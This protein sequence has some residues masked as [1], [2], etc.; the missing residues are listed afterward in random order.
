M[1]TK[2]S[3]I[4]CRPWKASA[5]GSLAQPD[6]RSQVGERRDVAQAAAERR[7]QHDADVVAPGLAELAVDAQRVVGTA[8]VLHVDPHEDPAR[9]RVGHDRRDERAAQVEI[10]L[11]PERGQLHGHVRVQVVACDGVQDR[12]VGIRHRLRLLRARHLLPEDVDGGE[13]PLRVEPGDRATRVVECGARDIGGGEACT[14]RRGTAGRSLTM[15]RSARRT[16][17]AILRGRAAGSP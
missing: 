4:S 15:T 3:R 13:L 14:T 8:R 16:A 1:R 5:G 12:V 9:G 11:Q 10:D 6:A 17:R 2:L 7:L